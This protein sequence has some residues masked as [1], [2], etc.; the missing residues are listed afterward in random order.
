MGQI[1]FMERD[2]R[3]SSKSAVLRPERKS[4]LQHLVP[5][6][7]TG[8]TEAFGGALDVAVGRR[9]GARQE[10]G[11]EG[12]GG[13]VEVGGRTGG[14]ARCTG[15]PLGDLLTH[16]IGMWPIST[17]SVSS[18]ATTRSSRCCSSRTLPGQL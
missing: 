2:T 11:L 5:E 17:V 10:R 18:S 1:I 3:A 6:R 16:R 12:A 13:R 8:E 14:E 9:K 15:L 7:M 4:E